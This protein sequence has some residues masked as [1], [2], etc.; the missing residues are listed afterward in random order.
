TPIVRKPARP[1]VS[2]ARD[3]PGRIS[4]SAR[5]TGENGRPSLT[6]ALVSTPSRSRKTA[7]GR[8]SDMRP[9]DR[10]PRVGP[11][12]EVRMAAQAV[13]EHGLEGLRV[14]SDLSVV[15]DRH[16]DDGI[17]YSFGVPAVPPDDA[18]HT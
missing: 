4:K 16:D 1:S 6:I 3:A 17:T 12:H 15:D 11:H 14:G 2:T 5:R 7:R 9:L 10:L 18:Q 13:P 8:F